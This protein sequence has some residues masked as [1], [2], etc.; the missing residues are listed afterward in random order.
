MFKVERPSHLDI[1]TGCCWLKII[2]YL[3]I[4]DWVGESMGSAI[5]CANSERTP[6]ALTA[7]VMVVWS[8]GSCPSGLTLVNIWWWGNISCIAPEPM[9]KE[10]KTFFHDHVTKTISHLQHFSITHDIFCQLVFL[11]VSSS[12]TNVGPGAT[13][14][15]NSSGRD[16]QTSLTPE[17]L[18]LILQGGCSSGPPPGGTCLDH[19]SG[20][21]QNWCPSHLSWLLSMLSRSRGSTLSSSWVT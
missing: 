21:V 1:W 14:G 8:G 12:S 5:P 7:P 18:S 9:D 20:G 15:G 4:F 6:P 17:T 3:L 11:L 16:A 19:H 2:C 10:T 13:G